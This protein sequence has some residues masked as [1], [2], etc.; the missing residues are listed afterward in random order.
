M[1]II[2]DLYRPYQD[3]AWRLS[4]PQLVSQY[5]QPSKCQQTIL[6][7]SSNQNEGLNT[8]R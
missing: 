5:L 3:D 7:H 6:E 1:R 4:L 2:R 8:T